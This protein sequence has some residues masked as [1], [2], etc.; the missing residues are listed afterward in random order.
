MPFCTEC[1]AGYATEARFCGS[2]GSAL[3][4]ISQIPAVGAKSTAITSSEVAL[5]LRKPL[6]PE[7]FDSEKRCRNCGGRRGR[8]SSCPTCSYSEVI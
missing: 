7:T 5:R 8:E 2:C 6:Y 4:A 3:S 1:G